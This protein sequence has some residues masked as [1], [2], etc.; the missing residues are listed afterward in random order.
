MPQQSSGESASKRPLPLYRP[1]LESKASV[2]TTTSAAFSIQEATPQTLKDRHSM[3]NKG[4]QLINKEAA[5]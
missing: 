2:M 3:F 1:H 5:A 4:N